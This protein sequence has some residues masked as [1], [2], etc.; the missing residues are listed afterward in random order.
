MIEKSDPPP[1]MIPL[2][3]FVDRLRK[4]YSDAYVPH[5]DQNDGG[6]E[7]EILLLFEKPGPMTDPKRGGS[8]LISQDNND[9]TARAAKVS[10]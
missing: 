4:R 10:S 3:A 2:V 5:F 6:I 9:P 7:A 8:G 1:H